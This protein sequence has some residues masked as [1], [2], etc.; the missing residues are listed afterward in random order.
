MVSKNTG[1]GKR[2]LDCGLGAGKTVWNGSWAI[3]FFCGWLL[4]RLGRRVDG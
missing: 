3:F 4:A 2:G 1:A